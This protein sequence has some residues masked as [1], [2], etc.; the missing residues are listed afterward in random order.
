[1]KYTMKRNPDYDGVYDTVAYH[2]VVDGFRV[3]GGIH[4]IEVSVAGQTPEV[5]WYMDLAGFEKSFSATYLRD[6]REILENPEAYR[7]NP[8]PIKI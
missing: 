1:M 2:V 8:R 5:E 7:P 3:Y 4:R 6:L